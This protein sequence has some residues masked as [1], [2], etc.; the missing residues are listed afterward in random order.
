MAENDGSKQGSVFASILLISQ[1]HQAKEKGETEIRFE[2][3]Q[4]RKRFRRKAMVQS[5]GRYLQIFPDFPIASSKSKPPVK[6]V[7]CTPLKGG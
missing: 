2:K 1:L 4:K 3:R 7:V 6:L 5:R